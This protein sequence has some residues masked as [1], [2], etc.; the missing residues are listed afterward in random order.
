MWGFADRAWFAL[1]LAMGRLL[2]AGRYTSTTIVR[3]DG[4]VQVRKRRRF[5]APLLVS[6]GGGVMRLLGTGV[7][8]M[9]QRQWEECERF[10]YATLHGTPIGIEADGTLVLPCL[11]GRTLAALLEEPSL[12]EVTRRTAIE[13]AAAALAEFHSRGFTHGD[14]MVENVIVDLDAALARWFDLRP[15]TIRTAQWIGGGRM[16]CGHWSRPA[17]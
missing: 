6:L 10:S 5:Y 11:A 7:R 8:I 14:A 3:R 13:L 17:C 15:F 2:R 4:M 12:E 1:C 9:P 16:T